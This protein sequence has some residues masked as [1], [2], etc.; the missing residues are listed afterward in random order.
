M[1]LDKLGEWSPRGAGGYGVEGSP[2]SLRLYWKSEPLA[3]DNKTLEQY[4]ITNGAT[5][6]YMLT[7]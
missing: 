7:K 6:G 1:I 4:G 5:L 2:D 3:D